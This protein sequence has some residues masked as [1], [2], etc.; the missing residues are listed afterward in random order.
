MLLAT[1]T[2]RLSLQSHF[3]SFSQQH[4]SGLCLLTTALFSAPCKLFGVFDSVF[5][6]AILC[7][8]RLTKTLCK[9]PGGWGIREGRNGPLMCNQRSPKTPRSC[10]RLQSLCLGYLRYLLSHHQYVTLCQRKRSG[11]R[12]EDSCCRQSFSPAPVPD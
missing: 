3:P 5:V 4:F 1:R 9:I 10:E 11:T 6:G 12:R 7:F 8:Q 2:S